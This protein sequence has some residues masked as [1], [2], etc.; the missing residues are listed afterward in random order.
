[1]TTRVTI[2]SIG[3]GGDGVAQLD[4]GQVFVPFSLPH[5][6]LNIAVEK[7]RGTIIA[8]L[9]S[10]SER[11]EPICQYY[12]ACGGCAL[13]HWA[14]EP[15]QNWKQGLVQSA[16]DG[17]GIDA[18]I[19]PLVP[20]A[21]QSRRRAVFAARKTEA[22][23]LLGYN[24]HQSHEIIDIQECPVTV[25][26]ITSRLEDIRGL[27]S[28]VAPGSKVFK[29]SVTVTESGL[30]IASSGCGSPDDATRLAVTRYVIEKG[31]AR[32]SSEDEI[33]VEPKKPLLHF[34]KVPVHIPAGTFLQA[35][36][37]AEDA[38]TA[39]VE[40]HLA[41]CKR[42]ADLFSGVGTF[43]LRIAEKSA[44][45]CVENNAP[46]LA[47]LDRG[48]RHVQGLKP[49]TV[50]KRDL[51][52]RPLMV[53]ELAPYQGVVFDPPRAGAEEQARELAKSSVAKIAAVSCNPVT[54]ARD[55][56]I[57]LKGGYKINKIV[58]IDQFLWT[59][60]VETVVL[61]SKK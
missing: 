43:G 49:V 9:K 34:G 60:H 30:D 17:Y 38:M 10:S 25:P 4:K 32:Y 14:D 23:Q 15:Y 44:V 45:H 52:R 6:E 37:A 40:S 8:M 13:Q 53:K 1:M 54:L 2:S 7:N 16:L 50:E 19:E 35:T 3:A 47:A 5:E 58:P 26:E 27:A 12:E 48:I 36:E 33:I 20:C 51:F 28:L 57:L 18:K 46:A 21:P 61:L 29:L 24:R 39:L 42:T 59:S 41:K 55:V 31:F 11:I 22:K 56:S